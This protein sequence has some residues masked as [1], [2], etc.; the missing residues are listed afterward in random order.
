MPSTPKQ[1]Q[2]TRHI[3][4]TVIKAINVSPRYMSAS[5][6][7]FII[8][9]YSFI[10]IVL[11]YIPQNYSNF[12]DHIRCI[13]S[14]DSIR[15]CYEGVCHTGRSLKD[16]SPDDYRGFHNSIC[17]PKNPVATNFSNSLALQDSGAPPQ[18]NGNHQYSNLL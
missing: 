18:L 4:V 17:D 7:I 5:S 9:T 1:S 2:P 11:D 10:I 14:L 3:F 8:S 16:S 13:D 12:P 15:S 6:S